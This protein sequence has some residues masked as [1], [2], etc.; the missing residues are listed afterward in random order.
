MAFA[1][2]GYHG[3][4]TIPEAVFGT[5]PTN[6]DWDPLPHVTDCSLQLK[7]DKFES[8]A[9][10]SDRALADVR[11]G[12][13]KVEGDLGFELCYGE[14][15]ELLEAF[16]GGTWSAD[17]VRQGTT[18]RSFSIMRRFADISQYQVFTGCCPTKLTLDVKPNGMITGKMSFIGS[19]MSAA[20]PAGST[21]NAAPTNSPMD[22]F[23]ASVLEGGATFA[24]ASALTLELNNGLEANFV[25]GSK[26]APQVSW[27]RAIMTGKLTAFFEDL[28]MYNKF[29]NETVSSLEF[30]TAFGTQALIFSM[31]NLQYTSAD[32]PVSDEKPIKLEMSFNALHHETYTCLQINRNADTDFS[33]S[34]SVSPSISPSVS[35]SISPSVSPSS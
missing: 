23:S 4:Y 32:N 35:P 34:P 12:T 10:R 16:L 8:K 11:L 9:L 33:A 27:G 29:L 30:T 19:N 15:D 24:L 26:Y 28:T 20:L 1:S 13:Y 2:G 3:T 22:C 7:R 21:Y 25:V 14:F 31:H 17:V 6:P 18:Q 5:T